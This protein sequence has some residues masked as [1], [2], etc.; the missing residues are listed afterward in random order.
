[1]TEREWVQLITGTC[2]IIAGLISL[3]AAIS[4]SRSSKKAREALQD[5]KKVVRES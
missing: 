2:N 5:I 1:M 3:A 4:S